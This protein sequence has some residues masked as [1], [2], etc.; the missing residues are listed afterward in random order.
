V[1]T[2]VI[3]GVTGQDGSYL[4]ELLLS[5][6]Y[7][8]VGVGRRTSSPNYERIKHL[9][10][11]PNFRYV[12]GD[13]TDPASVAGIIYE[14]DPLA[15]E[16]TTDAFDG[17]RYEIYNL[18]AQ[19]HVGV[20]FDQASL[21]TDVTYKG[22]LNIL[23]AIR[24]LL[25]RRNGFDGYVRFYQASSSEMFGS[26][27]SMPRD[28]DRYCIV[29]H[30]DFNTTKVEDLWTSNYCGRDDKEYI[31]RRLKEDL[32]KYGVGSEHFPLPFQDENTPFLPNSPYAIAKLA[33]HH[34]CRV[35]RDSYGIFAC[36]GILFNHESERRGE[37]FVTRKITRYIADLQNRMFRSD[38]P[39]AKLRLGNL[40][41]KRDWGH[42]EDYVRGMWMM[43]Q[44]GTPDDYVLATGEAHSVREFAQLAF[45]KVGIT[46][47]DEVL[48]VDPN[49][50]RPCEVPFLKG[51][52][53]K[54]LDKLGWKPQVGFEQ[55]VE[56]MVYADIAEVC[57]EEYASQLKASYGLKPS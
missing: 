32:E 18:A 28:Y 24:L 46:D 12:L 17:I 57:G 15:Q 26:A 8:V 7:K 36:S 39:P 43:L 40:D 35:Y 37:T 11:N 47:L 48:E 38:E 3:F 13:V 41:A 1:K 53:T 4:A 54:A 23:E 30:F 56:R 2:A 22:C 14:Y 5:K 34:L 49:L 20:S 44:Q 16:P 6:G 25:P 31:R 29:E 45:A 42:A 10:V 27:Y 19:S 50:F 55:L 52:A 33:A 9:F 51:D 21:T